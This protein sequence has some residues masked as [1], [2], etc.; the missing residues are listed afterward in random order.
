MHSNKLLKKLNNFRQQ[1]DFRLIASSRTSR[2]DFKV[3]TQLDHIL[4]ANAHQI[5][6]A[7]CVTIVKIYLQGAEVCSHGAD[8][9]ILNFSLQR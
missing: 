7:F 5:T 1:N 3:N 9:E 4:K 6:K 8:I 2:C